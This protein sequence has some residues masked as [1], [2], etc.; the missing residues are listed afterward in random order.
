MTAAVAGSAPLNEI[1]FRCHLQLFDAP[2]RWALAHLLECFARGH[3]THDT[4]FGINRSGRLKA[5]PALN[6]GEEPFSVVGGSR[7]V[8]ATRLPSSENQ[9]SDNSRISSALSM[10]S[11]G[12]SKLPALS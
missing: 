5:K 4:A 3:T 6:T 9:R 8:K 2:A 1:S 7:T 12:H 11:G 10:G